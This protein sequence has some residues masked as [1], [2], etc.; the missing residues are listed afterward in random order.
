MV[1]AAPLRAMDLKWSHWK[2][3]TIALAKFH[4]FKLPQD[5]G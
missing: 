5:F 4:A 1:L 3:F 2:V